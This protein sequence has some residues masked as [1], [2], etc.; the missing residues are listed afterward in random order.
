MFLFQKGIIPSDVVQ[1]QLGDCWLLAAIAC[2]A[3]FPGAIESVFCSMEKNERHKY[4]LK[5][6]DARKGE[7]RFKKFFIDDYVPCDAKTK[8]PIFA[9]PKGNE[10]WVLL[11][12]KAFA[13]FM[14]NYGRLDGGH[15]LWAFQAMTGNH[16]IRLEYDQG[17]IDEEDEEKH[18]N[19]RDDDDDEEEEDEDEDEDEEEGDGD[20]ELRAGPC[21]R[22]WT[23]EYD[24]ARNDNPC[25][26]YGWLDA[27]EAFDNHRLWKLLGHY[28]RH[29]ALIAASA[30]SKSEVKREDGI[31]AGHAYTIKQVFSH[32]K[33][34]LLNLRNPWGSFEWKGKWSDTDLKTWDAHPNIAKKVGFVAEDDGSFWMAF[35]D[36]LKIYNVLEICDRTTINNLHLNVNEDASSKYKLSILKG[37]M[38]GCFNFWCC[39]QGVKNVYCGRAESSTSVA[40]TESKCLSIFCPHINQDQGE[41]WKE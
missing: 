25:A 40:N 27:G 23:I 17:A 41:Q 35:D 36:F 10:L 33:I 21:W 24:R 31:V 18:G 13:K 30:N 14:G 11:L 1:G 32:K 22:K 15:T 19:A 2:L 26:D 39:C 12:E 34:K 29:C 5:L 3:E 20:G 38:K 7:E 37:C 9:A 6:Y 16:C 8:R 28:D 4:Y